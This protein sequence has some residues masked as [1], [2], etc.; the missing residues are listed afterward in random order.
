MFYN[1]LFDKY[2]HVRCGG[3]RRNSEFVEIISQFGETSFRNTMVTLSPQK[4]L[5]CAVVYASSVG[6]NGIV[7][8][9]S[10][11]HQGYSSHM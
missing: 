1:L 6:M 3:F 5:S 4:L 8:S 9:E 7:T 11:E 2:V 10:S